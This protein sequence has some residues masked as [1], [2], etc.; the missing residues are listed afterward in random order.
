MMKR[1]QQIIKSGEKLDLEEK[2]TM[3][4]GSEKWFWINLQPIINEDSKITSILN[5]SHDMTEKKRTEESLIENKELLRAI[6][7][8]TGDGILVVNNKGQVTHTN[9][10]FAELW[11]I[12]SSFIQARDDEK[13]IGFVLEQLDDPDAFLTKVKI[14]YNSSEKDTDQ[15]SFKDGRVFER[16]SYPLI[17]NDEIAGRVWNFRDI[18]TNYKEDNPPQIQQS[19]KVS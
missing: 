6:L 11:K 8:S 15:L 16:H 1:H 9:S 5:M 2:L 18:T 14:L 12:P 3:P 19:V 17:R 4:D 7:E 13:L 10:R